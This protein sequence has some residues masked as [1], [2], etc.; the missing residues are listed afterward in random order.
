MAITVAV[1][2]SLIGVIGGWTMLAAGAAGFKVHGELHG[3]D[4]KIT[5][6]PDLGTKEIN[7]AKR[8]A[9]YITIGIFVVVLISAY[10][11]RLQSRLRRQFHDGDHTNGRRLEDLI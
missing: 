11:Y 5:D 10:F 8:L 6:G 3:D 1:A 2:F 9:T 7:I 4:S